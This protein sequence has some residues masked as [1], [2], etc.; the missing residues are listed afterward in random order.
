MLSSNESKLY[1]IMKNYGMRLDE[2]LKLA[3]KDRQELADAITVS[4]QAISQV[5]TGKTKALTAENSAKAANF[6]KVD[7]FW[8]ATGEGK[9]RPTADTV[10]L[11]DKRQR[12]AE[13]FLQRLDEEESEL[14]TLYRC[15]DDEGRKRILEAAKDAPRAVLSGIIRNKP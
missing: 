8:L 15:T 11:P 4:V 3:E 14:L 10:E 6:L 12:N 13:T 9:S 5:I 1:N 7:G 2:A